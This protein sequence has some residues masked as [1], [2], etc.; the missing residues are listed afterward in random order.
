MNYNYSISILTG[1][2]NT[3]I[4]FTLTHFGFGLS[5]SVEVKSDRVMSDVELDFVFVDV[6]LDD[7]LSSELLLVE[8]ELLKHEEELDELS[9]SDSDDELE[10]LLLLDEL[11]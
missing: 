10:D 3:K 7:E 5:S 4:Q 8:T 9:D 2:Q 11:K 1:L 6:I